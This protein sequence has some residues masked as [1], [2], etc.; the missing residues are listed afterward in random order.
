MSSEGE[1][2]KV[3]KKEGGEEREKSGL[4][5]KDKPRIA[6]FAGRPRKKGRV[7]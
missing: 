1:W 3:R 2:Q 5:Q 7:G 6:F 4:R